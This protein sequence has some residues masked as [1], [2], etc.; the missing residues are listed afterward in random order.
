[1]PAADVAWILA[2]FALVLLMFPGLAMLY[3]GM[4]NGRSVL[5]MMMM[6]MSSLAVTTVVYVMVGHGLVL[7]DTVAGLRLIGD[8]F[9]FAFFSDL[10]T[11]DGAGTTLDSAFFALFA[12]ISVA[13][14]ASGA[15]GRMKFD[16]WMIFSAIWVLLV[17][18]P[19]AHWVFAADDED[20]GTKGGWMVNVL[21]LHDYAGGTAVHMNA[22]AAGLALAIFLGRRRAKS[23]DKP[24]N[25]PLMLIGAG[26]L[27]VGWIGFNGGTAGAADFLAQYVVMTSLLALAGGMLGFIIM[28]RLVN[29]HYTLLG[30]GTGMIAG[31]VG[32]TPVADAVHPVG[33][34][35]VGLLA[36][37]A[38]FGAIKLARRWGIDDS[39][40]VFAVHGVGGMAGAMF[41]VFFGTAAAPAERAGVFFGGSPDLIW[42]EIV[43]IVVTVGFSFCMTYAIAWVMDKI[44]PIRISEE[45]EGAGIDLALHSEAAYE[46]SMN[47]AAA[48]AEVDSDFADTQTTADQKIQ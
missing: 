38:A 3:G 20:A 47:T 6:V 13:L 12:A 39:A 22:G 23:G 19:M 16:A 24:H 27:A 34:I 25:L 43:A 4:L 40:D 15:A 21:D 8:P 46:R 18:A 29:G 32:I 10:M 41:V 11:D 36:S 2:A 5:N 35:C 48:E 26:L 37:A 7:G 45:D 30:L 42:R 44:H 17:Y 31:L 28:Q 1:M 14:V 9:E 33:A